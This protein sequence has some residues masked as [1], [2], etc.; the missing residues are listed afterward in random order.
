[1]LERPQVSL[2]DDLHWLGRQL[3]VL[4]RVYQ[5]YE[6]IIT[7][8]LQRQRLLRDEA[9]LAMDRPFVPEPDH[10]DE[11]SRHQSVRHSMMTTVNTNIPDRLDYSR[12]VA[13][14]SAAAGRFERLV[15]RIRLYCISEIET[16]LTEKESLTFMVLRF[17]LQMFITFLLLRY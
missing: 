9:R 1:M 14:S 8:I 16:C 13:L 17:F 15:D 7:R 3:A 12:G 6:L 11:P 4:K 5:S 2:V 10:I